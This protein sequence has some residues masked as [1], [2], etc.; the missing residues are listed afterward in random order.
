MVNSTFLNCSKDITEL[1][2]PLADPLAIH[3]NTY[4]LC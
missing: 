4:Y 2:D 1:A 3:P